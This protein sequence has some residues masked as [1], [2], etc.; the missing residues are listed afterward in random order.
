MLLLTKGL[1]V[2][3]GAIRVLPVVVREDLAAA[4]L[5]GVSVGG[6]GGPCIAAELAARRHSSV[7]VTGSDSK[8]LELVKTLFDLP[9]QN[10]EVT[11]HVDDEDLVPVSSQLRS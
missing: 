10:H 7:V 4:G 9:L 5:N 11:H 1:A 6:V 8:L 3:D 2:V